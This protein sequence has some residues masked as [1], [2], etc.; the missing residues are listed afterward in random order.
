MAA[1]ACLAGGL[2][3]PAKPHIQAVLVVLL[4]AAAAACVSAVAAASSVPDVTDTQKLV[5]VAPLAGLAGWL[6]LAT[7]LNA[8]DVAMTG[9]VAAL[10]YASPAQAPAAVALLGAGLVGAS[11]LSAARSNP[12][13]ASTLVYG[14]IG[15]AL[16]NAL[17][18]GHP[19]VAAAAVAAALLCSGPLLRVMR[20]G[21][22]PRTA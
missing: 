12:W 20:G 18:P 6:T 7:V 13:M 22:A 5:V 2:P 14:F 10:S 17:N 8:A 1:W 3:D 19:Y 11:A 9:G 21:A 4:G 15:A 16:S